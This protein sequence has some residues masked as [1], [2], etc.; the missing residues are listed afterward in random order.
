MV[1]ASAA[2]LVGVPDRNRPRRE[3]SNVGVGAVTLLAISLAAAT[4]LFLPGLLRQTRLVYKLVI[5]A[6]D[7]ISGVGRG[8]PV[9]MGGLERGQVLSVED[10][11]SAG[12]ASFVITF[13]LER[14]PPLTSN[15]RAAIV[16]NP[17]SNNS[18]INLV[19]ASD[20]K[21]EPAPVPPNRTVDL[22]AEPSDAALF[23][24]PAARKAFEG[25]WANISLAEAE[26]PPF[27]D[28]ARSRLRR[29]VDEAGNARGEFTATFDG[30]KARIEQLIE[31][32][33]AM[34]TD[35]AAV[36]DEWGETRAEYNR[37]VES[38]A[39][40]GL[41]ASLE[42]G[43]AMLGERFQVASIDGG[44]MTTTVEGL[45][46][47]WDDLK[48]SA[49]RLA[50]RLAGWPEDVDMRSVRADFSIAATELF[51]MTTHVARTALGVIFPNRTARSDARD[52]ADEIDRQLLFGIEQARAAES[53]LRALRDGV[54]ELPEGL[55]D[56]ER[57]IESLRRLDELEG[58]LFERRV[59]P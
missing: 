39:D 20:T 2:N 50:A 18:T 40:R 5:S 4:G 16:R 34:Q 23:M 47:R 27:I 25:T 10:T 11:P 19:P 46:R 31:R 7:D 21:G 57:L 54:E 41:I 13:E 53:A 37:L 36:R 56:L 45:A 6:G 33:R 30:N 44:S 52:A 43:F 22:N 35:L 24:T 58:T 8:T 48:A 51:A 55:V 32:Y 14:D 29:I 12:A 49:A 28:H 38:L 3:R 15:L 59:H 42:R 26:W 17:V 1:G 9:L